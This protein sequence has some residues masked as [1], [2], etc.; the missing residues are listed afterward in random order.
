MSETIGDVAALGPGANGA[1]G[2]DVGTIVTGGSGG[3]VG[4]ANGTGGFTG[5]AGGTGQGAFRTPSAG[6]GGGAGVYWA[7]TS[8]IIDPLILDAGGTGGAGGDPGGSGVGSTGGGG[9]GAG[10]VGVPSMLA[11]TNASATL[12]GGAGGAGGG[13]AGSSYG[14]GGGGGGDGLL[15]FGNNSSISNGGSIL[16]GAGGA[17]GSGSVVT[18]NAGNSGSGINAIGSGFT[19]TNQ[20]PGQ[21][22]G[23]AATGNGAPGVGVH[24]ANGGARIDNFGLISGGLGGPTGHGAAIYFGGTNNRLVAE[25]GST[26][27]GVVEIGSAASAIVLGQGNATLNGVLLDGGGATLQMNLTS[28]VLDIGGTITGTGDVAS[29]G[30]ADLIL[31]GVTLTGALTLDHTGDTQVSGATHTTG[32]QSFAG[33]VT[34]AGDS[35]FTSTGGAITFSGTVDGARAMTVST[36]GALTFGSDVGSTTALTNL[37]TT[38]ASFQAANIDAQGLAITTTGGPITQ[39]GIFN[40]I[41]ASAFNAGANSVTLTN[42]NTFAGDVSVIGQGININ[43]ASDMTVVGVNNAS[44]GDLTF[45]SNG[46][47]SLSTGLA[48]NGNISL[49]SQ[50]GVLAPDGIL[51]AN[52]SIGLTGDTGVTL[53]QNV[54]TLGTLTVNSNGDLTQTAG[55][56]T[57]ATFTANTGGDIDLASAAN[58][59][60]TLGNVTAAN[61]SLIDSQAL[62]VTGNVTANNITLNDSQGVLVTNAINATGTLAIASGTPLTVGNGGT[63][64]SV[65]GNISDNS[66]LFFNRSDT[67]GFT[68]ALDGNG[69]L[70]QKGSGTLLFDGNGTAYAG[71]TQVQAGKLIVGSTAGSTAVL[72]GPVDVATGA[73]LGGHGRIAGSVNMAGGSTLSPG[74]SIG[75]LTVDGDLTMAQGSLM[76]AELGAAGNGDQVAVGGNLDLQGGTVNVSDAG[77][78]GPGVYTLFSWGGAL[79]QSNGG[80]SLGT[81]PTGHLVALQYLTGPKQINLLDLTSATLNFW[82]ANGLASASQMGGGTGTWSNTSATWTDSV[83]SVTGA[84]NPQPGFAIFGGTPGTVT[85][86]NGSGQVAATGMQFDS[87]GY[88]VVGGPL[89]LVTTDGTTPVIRV[90]NGGA[91]SAGYTATID[92]ELTGMQGLAKNDAGTLVLTANNTYTGDIV[93]NGGVLSVAADANLGNVANGVMLQGGALRVT[94][95]TH[96]STNRALALTTGGAVDIADASNTFAWNGAITGA[97]SLE[98]LGAGTLLL[99]H[100]NAYA[101]GTTVGAGTLRLG[102]SGAIG[103]GALSLASGST[104]DLAASGLALTNAASVTGAATVNVDG[105]NVAGL[106][107]VIADGSSAGALTKTGTG[108]LHLT[109]NNTYTGATTIAAGTLHVGDGGTQGAIAGD[110]VDHGTLVFDRSDDVTYGAALSGEGAFQKLGSG[111]LHLTGNS[112]AFTG[113]TDITAGTLQLDGSLGGVLSMANGTV[114]T[115]SGTGG[116]LMLQSGAEVSPGGQGVPATLSFAGDLTMAAGTHYTVDVTDAGQG[117]RIAVAGHATL[118]GGSVVSL[119]TGE[120]WGASHTYEILSA[121]N[122]VTGTFVGVSSNLAF[123]TP[124]L[125]YTANAVNLTLSRNEVAF[126]DVAVTRNERASAAAT[127]ALGAGTAV[128]DTVLRLDA[129]GAR[130]AF[131]SLSG[132]IQASTRTAIADD[133]RYQREAINNHLLDTDAANDGHGVSAWASTWGH[134]GHYDGDGNAARTNANGSGLLVGADT[135]VGQTTRLGFAVGTGQVSVSTPARDSSANVRTRTAGLYAGGRE[136]AFQ[137]QAGALYGQEDIRTH[138]T[139]TVG[140]LGGRVNSDDDAHAAQGYVEAAYVFD[141]TR[142]SW[143]PFVNVAYQQLRTPDIREHGAFG[144]LDIDAGRSAQTFG[145]LG[146]RGE[147]KLGDSGTAIFGSVGWRHASGDVDASSR[148]RF[149]GSATSFDI[150]GVP[151]AANA[152]MATAGWRFRP[153][154]NVVVDATYSGQ[155]AGEA[156]DQ[157]ARLS[158]DWMF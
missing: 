116:S 155:F 117:D 123:L 104:L 32:L 158:V 115:G 101:G 21:I 45:S 87:D 82:N 94:G 63:I 74:N 73:G 15:V 147:A 51:I 29:A 120:N 78:M 26:A 18:G 111:T 126:P 152:G 67:V 84:M 39:T 148:M 122:G 13:G 150:Q 59:I 40:I 137:W 146:L 36:P 8:L 42:A 133:Q 151:I 30:S 143:A 141:G 14:G 106:G 72:A 121:A 81:V 132:E 64:G 33:P 109:A 71:S 91:L 149:D 12:Q 110:V 44:E 48:T 113:T 95:H 118:Q 47:L 128:Y 140:D 93:I 136:G 103:S 129:A 37:S 3:G 99:N 9:G 6:G 10:F 125:A 19:V 2:D 1:Q 144:A 86:D 97:G 102:D 60:D 61:V 66:I 77:G 4:V 28:G 153:A 11:I 16:G 156:R 107:G 96:T 62:A 25:S 20:A 65:S 55:S 22:V 157:S 127:E 58:S 49:A 41:G 85:I 76:D 89:Q 17:G 98:K 23:G 53:A 24:A 56:V 90:G 52:G 119:G 34:L 57:A 131:D 46:V 145:T 50:G 54:S 130:A 142:G 100:A 83:G 108:E 75:T 5:I 135:L 27:H 92:A 114:L 80:L 79:T 154:A 70:V 105:S 112:S 31:R 38:S 138:R 88:R 35:Q 68:G 7:G 69:Q 134:W 124:S 43:S 139:V